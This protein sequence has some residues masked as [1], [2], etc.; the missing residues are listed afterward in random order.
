ME[1]FSPSEETNLVKNSHKWISSKCRSLLQRKHEAIGKPEFGREA[2]ACS[3]GLLPEYYKYID[4]TK[5]KLQ[6]MKP[7]CKQYWRINRKF[8]L[9]PVPSSSI[10]ALKKDDG[11][12]MGENAK[13]RIICEEICCK[14]AL[15]RN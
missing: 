8:M 15:T 4:R 14:I 2:K 5:K 7:N 11:W 3:D 12:D 6:D 13:M 1:N 10:P 9:R